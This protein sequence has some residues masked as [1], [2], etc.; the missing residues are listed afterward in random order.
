MGEKYIHSRRGYAVRELCALPEFAHLGVTTAESWCHHDHWVERRRDLQEEVRNNVTRALIAEMTQ[1]RIDH[2]RKLTSLRT[3][4][5]NVGMLTN[6][7]GNVEF[8]LQ[9]KSLEAWVTAKVKLDQHIG[10]IQTTVAGELPQITA[11]A[12]VATD[13]SE[14]LPLSLKPRL[15]EDESLDLALRL[16]DKR[17]REDEEAAARWKASQKGVPADDAGP[18]KKK[19]PPRMGNQ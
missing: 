6:A 3:A 4:F 17:M 19:P 8:K 10:K 11:E 5:D 15:T 16:R 14:H 9:P 7:E 1:E 18:K 2:L 12:L 13:R